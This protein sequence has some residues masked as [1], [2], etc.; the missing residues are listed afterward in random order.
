MACQDPTRAC[1]SFSRAPSSPPQRKSFVSQGLESAAQQLPRVDKEWLAR[2]PA[3]LS[4]YPDQHLASWMG[5]VLWW[6][7]AE[8]A[9][10]PFVTRYNHHMG[11][12]YTDAQLAQGLK[13]IG[14]SEKLIRYLL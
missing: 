13:D 14:C 1:P 5:S 6:R 8:E 2:L 9:L 3:L 7:Y 4:N 12:Q 11:S 10:I